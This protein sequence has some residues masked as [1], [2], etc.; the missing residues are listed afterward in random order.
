MRWDGKSRG[1]EPGCADENTAVGEQ[2]LIPNSLEGQPRSPIFIPWKM[3][4]QCRVLR[5]KVAGPDLCPSK[6]FLTAVEGGRHRKRGA[7]REALPRPQDKR[8]RA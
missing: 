7:A 5:K 3:G 1:L 8:T 4:S 6:T 2:G